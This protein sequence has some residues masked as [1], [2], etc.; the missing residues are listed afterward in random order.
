MSGEHEKTS[1]WTD[2]LGEQIVRRSNYVLSEVPDAGL[3]V[4]QFN[5][6]INAPS[7]LRRLC[8]TYDSGLEVSADILTAVDELHEWLTIEIE[9]RRKK[10]EKI[11]G[12]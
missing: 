2:V 3:L 12:N 4:L 6:R 5:Q 9:Q 7:G 1:V 10:D 8:A 11:S